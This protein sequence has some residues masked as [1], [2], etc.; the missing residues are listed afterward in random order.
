MSVFPCLPACPPA[1]LSQVSQLKLSHAENCADSKV[2]RVS[3]LRIMSFVIFIFRC[4]HHIQLFDSPM[5]LDSSVWIQIV[6]QTPI[7]CFLHRFLASSVAT[8]QAKPNKTNVYKVVSGT[9]CRH[10]H[11][12]CRCISYVPNHFL[13]PPTVWGLRWCNF[14]WFYINIYYEIL[15]LYLMKYQ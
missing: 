1:C 9:Y 11:H 4:F 8:K 2:H 6:G 10:F 3:G 13:N 12:S 15:T 7:G 14:C 5:L